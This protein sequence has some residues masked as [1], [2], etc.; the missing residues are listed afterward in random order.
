MTEADYRDHI[1]RAIERRLVA[2]YSV[3]IAAGLRAGLALLT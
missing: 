2:A 3:L 1:K